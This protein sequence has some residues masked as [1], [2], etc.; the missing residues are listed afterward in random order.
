MN[1]KIVS[2]VVLLGCFLPLHAFL[3]E[4]KSQE[5]IFVT[6]FQSIPHV[7]QFLATHGW[8]TQDIDLIKQPLIAGTT[9]QTYVPQNMHVAL[10]TKKIIQPKYACVKP[11]SWCLS[12]STYALWN[13]KNIQKELRCPNCTHLFFALFS[14][15]NKEVDYSKLLF[16]AALDI[17]A[18]IS[19]LGNSSIKENFF[20]ERTI[21]A[22]PIVTTT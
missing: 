11:H 16:F 2:H 8:K 20:E 4:N 13:W 1:V 5:T 21:E 7:I 9:E 3:F 19:Y 14:C 17:K 10:L 6:T 18:Q 15:S 12:P 22:N